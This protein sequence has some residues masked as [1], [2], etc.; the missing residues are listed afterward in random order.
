MSFSGKV[1]FAQTAWLDG[2]TSSLLKSTT[3]GEIVLNVRVSGIPRSDLPPGGVITFAGTLT[4]H[5]ES[6]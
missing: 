1:D 2:A 5:L 3:T 4:F 6:I